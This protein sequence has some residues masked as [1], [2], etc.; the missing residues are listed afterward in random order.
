MNETVSQ[1]VGQ[2]VSQS[3]SRSVSQSV[4]QLVSQSVSLTSYPSV[5]LL[6]N[7]LS[8][9]ILSLVNLNINEYVCR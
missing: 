2:S 1:S 6:V 8:S 4:S 3:V 5:D 7:R 9:V